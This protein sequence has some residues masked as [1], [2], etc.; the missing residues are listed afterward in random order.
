MILHL[1]YN[2]IDNRDFSEKASSIAIFSLQRRLLFVAI[3]A[4]NGVNVTHNGTLADCGNAFVTL[5]HNATYQ[6]AI[7]RILFWFPVF[8]VAYNNTLT[9]MYILVLHNVIVTVKTP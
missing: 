5:Q 2:N 6:K 9:T 1:I 7:L 8:Y 4:N 3:T